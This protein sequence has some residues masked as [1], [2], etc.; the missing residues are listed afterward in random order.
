MTAVD[1]A[2]S[3]AARS[4][5]VPVALGMQEGL[6]IVRH[7]LSLLGLALLLLFIGLE[8]DDGPRDAFE[9]ITSGPTFFLGVFVFFAAHLVAS[10]DRRVDST[11]LLAASP[12]ADAGRVAGL[13]VAALVPALLSLALVASV[14]VYNSARG[15]YEVAPS[16]FHLVQ[17]PLTVLGG[18]LLGIMV[19]RLVWVPGAPLLVMVAM[20][21]A[22]SWLSSQPATLQPL[23]TYVPWAVWSDDAGWAGLHPGSPAWHAG[24]L[25]ALCAMA[26]TGAFLREAVNTR[27]VLLIGAGFS[28]VAVAAGLLQLP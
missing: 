21:V 14:D 13:C 1:L 20:V 18:A 26:A 17:G 9:V 10:R 8:H 7:P 12:V 22:N 6:R 24:Y 16:L 28:A 4:L 2:P 15:A 27:R 25:A 3:A 5:P 23:A 19:A 11:E